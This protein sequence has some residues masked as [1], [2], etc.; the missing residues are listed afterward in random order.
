MDNDVARLYLK[1]KYMW[2]NATDKDAVFS[3]GNRTL[4]GVATLSEHFCRR[5]HAAVNYAVERS[6]DARDP[7]VEPWKFV[8]RSQYLDYLTK[9]PKS[10]TAYCQRW[11]FTYEHGHPSLGDVKARP[12]D[13]FIHGWH[14]PQLLD[15]TMRSTGLHPV[16]P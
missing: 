11:P 2:T 10:S 6:S 4:S 8:L 12:W 16:F 14:D 7:P 13:D 9:T 5:L 15:R 3:D 1:Y